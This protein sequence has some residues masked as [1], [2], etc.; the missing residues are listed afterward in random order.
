MTLAWC[1]P[2]QVDI[3]DTFSKQR[4]KKLGHLLRGPKSGVG[5]GFHG[6]ILA[7]VASDPEVGSITSLVDGISTI[8]ITQKVPKRT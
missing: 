8:P 4:Q 7:K 1:S 3:L 6:S 2:G 5:N